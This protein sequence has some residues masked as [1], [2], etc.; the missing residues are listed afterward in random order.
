MY[1]YIL[2]LYYYLFDDLRFKVKFNHSK[3]SEFESLRNLH[4]F[5]ILALIISHHNK[6]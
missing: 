2:I 1:T 4:F 3:G 6:S 5:S